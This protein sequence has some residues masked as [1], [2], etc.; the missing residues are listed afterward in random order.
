MLGRL[1][2]PRYRLALVL[3]NA[4]ADLITHAEIAL[5][6]GIALLGRLAKPRDRLALVLL[7][8]MALVVHHAERELGNGMALIGRLA[9]P[10]HGLSEVPT[11][12]SVHSI[13]K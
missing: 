2:K 10:I 8:A 3:F 1:A 7:N 6:G 11:L 5:R 12:I 9:K 4:T 13:A